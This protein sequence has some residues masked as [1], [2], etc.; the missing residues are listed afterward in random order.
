MLVEIAVLVARPR[1]RARRARRA[2]PAL[3]PFRLLAA[4]YTDIFRG[5]PVIL[6]VYLIGFGVP[7]LELSGRA[8]PTR[9]CSAASRSTLCYGAYVAE[10]YRA[11]IESIHPSQPAAALSLGLT[12]AQSTALRRPARRRSGA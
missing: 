7:G 11:G 8:R 12:P 3:F 10:V 1:G 4:S 5:L 2:P 9:S 6:V